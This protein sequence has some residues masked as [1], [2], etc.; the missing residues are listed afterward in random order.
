M[1]HQNRETASTNDGSRIQGHQHLLLPRE[2]FGTDAEKG[3]YHFEALEVMILKNI[4]ETFTREPKGGEFASAN[5]L[6]GKKSNVNETRM[7]VY[8]NEHENS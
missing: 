2:M 4:E 3:A 6:V 1:E 5:P 8:R 7:E